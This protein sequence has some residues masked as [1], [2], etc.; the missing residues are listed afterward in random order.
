MFYTIYKITNKINNSIYIGCHKTNNLDDDYMGS[1][2]IL[3]RAQKKYGIENF[4]KE[5]LEVFDNPKI[6]FEM[7]AMLVNSEFVDREDTYNLKEGGKGGF[8]HIGSKHYK[9]RS[10]NK[11]WINKCIV[12]LKK[13]KEAQN[14]LNQNDPEWLSRKLEALSK[15]MIEYYEKG[16][17]N[18]FKGKQHSEEFKENMKGH[19]RQSGNKN[20]QYGTMWI[21]SITEK[22]S[23]KI[24]KDEFSEWEAKGWLKGR[25]MKFL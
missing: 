24:K 14:W 17:K 1:G 12:N 2:T 5:I 11:V 13:G 22:V 18:G 20:S 16:G 3:K 23:K 6:M 15:S 9:T 21:H 25:K 8:D 19:T 7:E 4:E 10:E